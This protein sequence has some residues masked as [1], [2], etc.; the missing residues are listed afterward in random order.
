MSS[1]RPVQSFHK[2]GGDQGN[3]ILTTLS[4]TLPGIQIGYSNLKVSIINIAI[5]NFMFLYAS[6]LLIV[7]M[8]GEY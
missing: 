7:K 2:R 1:S 4:V 3:P 8:I 6:N 5:S